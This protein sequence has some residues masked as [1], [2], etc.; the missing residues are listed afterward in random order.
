MTLLLAEATYLGA[1]RVEELG[2][3]PG[4]FNLDALKTLDAQILAQ[5]RQLGF[6][7]AGSVLT[8]WWHN[9]RAVM[10]AS[11]LG[12]F[13]LGVAGT[14]VLMLPMAVIG[15]FS[16]I[17]SQAGTSPFIIL[18][19]VTMPHGILE[20]PA[21][22]LS[23]ATILQVGAT[24]VTPNRKQTIGEGLVSSLA[25]WAKIT[26][27]LVIPLFLG[28]AFLEVFVSPQVIVRLLGGG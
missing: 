4:M 15:L 8:V 25:D 10:L 13:T 11:L 5:F 28:A 17:I 14:L 9:L 21:M 20:I 18:A 23:G 3:T 24:L 16:G 1:T 19:A 6:F 2:I 7:S 26:L 27:A 12:A 22:I